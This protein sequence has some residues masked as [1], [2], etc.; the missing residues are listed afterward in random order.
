MI[1]L[2]RGSYCGGVGNSPAKDRDDFCRM[3]EPGGGNLAA[4]SPSD[5]GM[6]LEAFRYCR[7]LTAQSGS[8]FSLSFALLPR[9][10]RL[11]MEVIYA[12]CRAIDDVVD[13]GDLTDEEARAQLEFW[14]QE[15]RISDQGAPT[16]PIGIALQ[17]ARRQFDI[18]RVYF[19]E[20]ILG[21]QM[22]LR[23]RR[24]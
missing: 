14:R 3:G 1:P 5:S 18:P 12:Y 23:P 4:V 22:D 9:S 6:L 17:W 21:V 7:W 2:E 11:G 24:Y 10:R 20:L 16:H 19:E 13:Q 8:H 15:L